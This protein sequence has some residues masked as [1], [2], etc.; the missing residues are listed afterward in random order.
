MR[1][2]RDQE[3]GYA[4]VIAIVFLAIMLTIGF[5]ALSFVD[6]EQ[7]SSRRERTT[8]ARLN[9][10][11]GALAAQINELSH[12]WRQ[13]TPYADCTQA[14]VTAGCPDATRL[15]SHFGGVDFTLDPQWDV[16]VRDDAP[17][18][19]AGDCT[20]P[21]P[22]YYD[23]AQVLAQPHYDAN[24]NCLVW[25]RAEGRLKGEKRVVVAQARAEYRALRFPSAPF[26]AGSFEITNT[27]NKVLVDGQSFPGYVR[28]SQPSPSAS[29]PCMTY[30]PAKGQA[31]NGVQPDPNQPVSVLDGA[32][33]ELLKA[34]AQKNSTY[35]PTCPANPSGAVVYVESGNCAYPMSGTPQVVNGTTK[36]GMFIMARGTLQIGNNQVWYG[37]IHMLNGQGCGSSA[38]AACLDGAGT[39]VQTAGN[40]EIHGGIF[41]DGAGR[42]T[43]GSSG[44]SGSN[45]ANLIYDPTVLGDLRYIGTASVVQNSWRELIPG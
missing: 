17:T 1:R 8:E 21:P 19:S 18:G 16:K 13:D 6:G 34:Q 15:K 20:G 30:D 41:I 40:P 23:D 28:C 33:V 12:D 27:G 39:V 37:A 2:A 5:A 45:L 26:I 10:T 38:G 9:L 36:T 14:S 31:P 42:L 24:G 7:S 3:S 4:L 11:E 44:G 22:S 25:V 29:N 43:I 35:Y 32:V